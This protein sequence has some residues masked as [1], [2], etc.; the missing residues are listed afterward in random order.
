[1]TYTRGLDLAGSLRRAG[2]IGG[3]LARTDT[4]GSTFYHPDG[5]G[6]ITALIDGN[7]NIVA[8]YLYNP[9]GKLIGQWGPMASANTLQFS[10]MPQRRGITLYPFRGYEPNFQRF[11][12]QDPIGEPGGIN[13]YR[14]VANNPL[15]YVDP[16]GLAANTISGLGG[17]WNSDPYGP[18]GS[19]YGPGY[20]YTTRSGNFTPDGPGY[21]DL[22]SATDYNPSDIYSGGIQTDDEIFALLFPFLAPDAGVGNLLESKCPVV[23]NAPRTQAELVKDFTQNPDNWKRLKSQISQTTRSGQKGG[24]NIESIWKNNETGETVSTHEAFGPSGK[25]LH[26]ENPSPNLPGGG[27]IRP[28]NQSKMEP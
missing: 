17:T 25:S 19:F 10:S 15:R 27:A 9:F 26:P 11:L 28:G 6:N 5:V 20:L 13:L 16:L 3:L 18:G 22:T 23:A 8:R 21:Y 24:V 14:F 1:V 12:N 4:N 2:G 7:E